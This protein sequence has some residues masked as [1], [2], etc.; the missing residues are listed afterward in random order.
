[1]NKLFSKLLLLLTSFSSSLVICIFLLLTYLCIDLFSI[2]DISNFLSF[3]WDVHNNKYGIST[4]LF[5]TML[6][7]FMALFLAFVFSFSIS[8]V[9]FLSNNKFLKFF[10]EKSVLL[11]SA[12]P[13]VIYAF[14]ALMTL[15]PFISSFKPSS[16]LSILVASIVLSL[17]LSQL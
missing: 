14:S 9:I 6:I 17:Y 3:D 7:S 11:M 15:V 8:S 12:I 16:T 13:T 1:M 5:T 10:L 4:M 2:S